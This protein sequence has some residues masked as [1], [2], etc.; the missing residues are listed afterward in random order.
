VFKRIV[1][2][3]WSSGGGAKS[4]VQLRVKGALC[5]AVH[6]CGVDHLL[7]GTEY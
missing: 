5:R 3:I 2:L 6:E 7:P 4:S 1:S